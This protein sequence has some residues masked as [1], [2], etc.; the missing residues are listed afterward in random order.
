MPSTLAAE[1]DA[2]PTG[3]SAS[4]SA[5]ASSAA[6]AS[7]MRQ[8]GGR[9]KHTEK[10]NR[11]DSTSPFR[12]EKDQEHSTSKSHRGEGIS[13]AAFLSREFPALPGTESVDWPRGDFLLACLLCVAGTI[14]FVAGWRMWAAEGLWDAFPYGLLSFFCLCPG[15]YHLVIFIL[16]FLKVPGFSFRLLH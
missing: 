2:C 15:V 14:F 4:P 5:G 11:R 1:E 10:P 16:I 7:E 9:G 6:P 12:Y 3:G 13:A 8:R